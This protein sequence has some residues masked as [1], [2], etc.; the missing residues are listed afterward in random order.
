MRAHVIKNG[1]VI[2]TIEVKSLDFIPGLIDASNGGQI[3][4]DYD[5]STFIPPP[6]PP[7]Q[8]TDKALANLQ[9]IDTK[10]IRGIREFL[11]SKFGDDPLMPAY[12]KAHEVSAKETRG[13]I[14]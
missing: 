1:K 6:A 7:E 4:D 5:G 11:V 2:N 10:S 14:K 9:T 13:Q 3:G 8:E 12:L